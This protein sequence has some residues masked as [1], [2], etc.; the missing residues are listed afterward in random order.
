MSAGGDDGEVSQSRRFRPESGA[1]PPTFQVPTNILRLC[2]GEEAGSS[3][4]ELFT[5]HSDSEISLEN[6]TA[7]SLLWKLLLRFCKDSMA[8]PVSLDEQSV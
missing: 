1:R 7:S 8:T 5:N 6:K 4:S 3:V 2:C